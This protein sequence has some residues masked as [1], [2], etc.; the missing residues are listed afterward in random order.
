MASAQEEQNMETVEITGRTVDDAIA[1]AS[2][3]LGIPADRLDYTIVSDGSKG[4]LGIGAEDAR[5][6]VSTQ[7][8]LAPGEKPPEGGYTAPSG[9][10]SPGA[11]AG[12][13]LTAMRASSAR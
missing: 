11:R 8:A 5:I 1:A 2:A 12:W 10:F 3:Q 4:I 13:V 6:A 9:G 7:P